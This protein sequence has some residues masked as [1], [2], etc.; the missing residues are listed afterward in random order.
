[1]QQKFLMWH[2]QNPFGMFIHWGVYAMTNYHEQIL[3]RTQTTR[4]EYEKL[5]LSFNPVQYDPEEWVLLA[6]Q[7]GMTYICF[8]TKHHDGFCMWDTKETGYNIMNTPYK[9]DTLEMLSKACEKHD[10]KLCLYYSV[11]DWYHPNAY[12]KSSS[13]QIPPR[14]TDVPDLE[15]Y[16]SFVIAQIT[17]LLTNY[18]KIHTFFWDIP[19]VTG[20]PALLDRSINDLLRKLQPDILINNRGFDEGDFSTPERS[21]PEGNI[22]STPTEACQSIG[23]QSWGY[24]ENED[25]Y[26]S[27]FLKQSIDKIISMGGNYLLNVGPM[28]NGKMPQVAIDIVQNVGKWFNNVKESFETPIL[29]FMDKEELLTTY[30]DNTLYIHLHKGARCSGLFLDPITVMPAKVTVLN[31]N[32]SPKV[33][34]DCAPN[35]FAR[36]DGFVP[37]LHIY[38]LPCDELF[39]EP[40]ILKLE[41]ENLNEVIEIC[42]NIQDTSESR[43]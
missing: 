18:G 40:M 10:M 7:A 5:Y 13:H 11:P 33:G 12:I 35:Y 15:K 29:L 27:N 34:L 32:L 8:T 14:E 22:F 25:Y 9:K 38:N 39:D 3:R 16:K 20:N 23:W 4:D 36:K 24:R 2:A 17:E 41:F 26:S 31:N 1:M 37:C 42:K 21:V 28:D 6:K 43:F 30:K 19:P